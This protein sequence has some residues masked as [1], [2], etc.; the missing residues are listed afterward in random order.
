MTTCPHCG[1]DASVGSGKPRSLEQHRRFFKII[2]EAF[3]HWPET[4]ETQFASE[5]DCRYWLTM[6]AGYRDVSGRVTLVGMKPDAALMLAT[7][8]LRSA[9]SYARPVIHKGELIVWT[10]RSIKFGSMPH[11]EFCKLNDDV[12][13][14]IER[15]IGVS[16]EKLLEVAA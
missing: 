1:C 12:A 9:G 6:T 11:A 4:H 7:A 3:T 8:L 10:P 5:S 15:E 2:R 13:A 16:V 14:V